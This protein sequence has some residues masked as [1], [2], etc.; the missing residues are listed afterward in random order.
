MLLLGAPLAHAQ[1]QPEQ[2]VMAWNISGLWGEFEEEGSFS[3]GGALGFTYDRIM[4]GG[5]WALGLNLYYGR[6]VKDQ[7]TYTSWPTTFTVKLLVGWPRYKA[8]V[9]G[10]IGLHSERLDVSG[11]V[12]RSFQ[13]VAMDFAIPLGFYAFFTEKLGAQ[14][15]YQA[16]FANSDVIKNGVLHYLGVGILFSLSL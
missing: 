12:Y 15:Q 14:V 6:A 4:P 11:E 2:S 10:G 7:L 3:S 9:G 13:D 1:L 16:N 5:K 8:Y